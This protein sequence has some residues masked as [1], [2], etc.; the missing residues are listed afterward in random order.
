MRTWAKQYY[1]AAVRAVADAPDD[2]LSDTWRRVG[3]VSPRVWRD[4]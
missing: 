2:G 3:G 4:R 1:A